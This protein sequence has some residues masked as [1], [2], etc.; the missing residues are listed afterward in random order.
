MM[1]SDI[2]CRVCAELHGRALRLLLVGALPTLA[3]VAALSL[4]PVPVFAGDTSSLSPTA[5]PAGAAEAKSPAA[6]FGKAE[7]GKQP[8]MLPNLPRQKRGGPNSA[9]ATDHPAT[10]VEGQNDLIKVIRPKTLQ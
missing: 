4:T 1:V 5:L 3:I 6:D 10:P 2:A 9:P 8:A 7:S